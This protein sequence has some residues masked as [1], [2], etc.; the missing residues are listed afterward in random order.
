MKNI[1]KIKNEYEMG[2]KSKVHIAKYF[3]LSTTTLWRMAKKG[4][5]EYGSINK[6]ALDRIYNDQVDTLTELKIQI[7]E[8][9][10]NQLKKLRQSLMKTKQMDEI[11]ILKSKAG[12]LIRAIQS[13]RNFMGLPTHIIGIATE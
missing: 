9:H 1:S 7:M 4:G 11:V 10:L 12:L 6:E 5:W 3:G 2:F 8:D 13:E